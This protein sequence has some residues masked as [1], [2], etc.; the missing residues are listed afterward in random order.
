MSEPADMLRTLLDSLPAGDPDRPGIRRAIS[1]LGHTAGEEPTDV[2]VLNR[3]PGVSDEQWRD[4]I[5]YARITVAIKAR[6]TAEC[7]D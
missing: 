7:R 6:E 2:L 3:P 4:M 1:A 5:G